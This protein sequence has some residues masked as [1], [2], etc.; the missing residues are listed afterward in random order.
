MT[1]DLQRKKYA[2][3]FERFDVDGDGQI[4]Q[5]DIDALVQGW[6]RDLGV[7]VNTPTWRIMVRLSNR[8]WQDIRGH[9]D[10]D[11]NK[12]VSLDEWVAAHE[13]P[14]FV[15][16]IAIPFGV[17]AFELA[18]TDRD[19][20]VSLNEWT[21]AQTVS[22]LTQAEALASFQQLDG[23][24][25]GYITKDDYTRA[26]EEFYGSTDLAAVGNQLAGRV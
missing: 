18:D 9:F 22:G 25:D 3:A 13:D 2:K 26:T 10:R 5:T 14:A 21:S 19:G 17:A 15:Q 20:K 6:A 16:D 7:P 11:G 24:A 4:E 23:D 8:L 1:S 12:I